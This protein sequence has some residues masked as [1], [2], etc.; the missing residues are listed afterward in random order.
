VSPAGVEHGSQALQGDDDDRAPLVCADGDIL[1]IE[2]GGRAVSWAN[3]PNVD[4][5]FAVYG[6]TMQD[7]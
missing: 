2:P 6:Q 4:S 5:G 3:T 1:T 7:E